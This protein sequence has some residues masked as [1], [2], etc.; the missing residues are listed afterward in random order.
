[1]FCQDPL[2]S[3]RLVLTLAVYT[4]ETLHTC[5]RYIMRRRRLEIYKLYYCTKSVFPFPEINVRTKNTETLLVADVSFRDFDVATTD[6]I[7][8]RL[9]LCRV[10]L[11]WVQ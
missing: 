1:M 11:G 5:D 2:S 6:H 4:P 8:M 10:G 3:V 7:Y 9:L